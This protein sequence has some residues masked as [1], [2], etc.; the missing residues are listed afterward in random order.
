MINTLIALLK[1]HDQVCFHC[2][3]LHTDTMTCRCYPPEAGNGAVWP[4]VN[5]TDTC[6]YWERAPGRI[7]RQRHEDRD[8][9]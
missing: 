9:A 7:I 3:H 4:V 5:S 8:A 2:R 1:P 6:S